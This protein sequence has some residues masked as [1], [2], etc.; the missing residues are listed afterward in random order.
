[1]IGL[2]ESRL[3]LGLFMAC[4]AIAGPVAAYYAVGTSEIAGEACGPAHPCTVKGAE[5][6]DEATAKARLATGTGPRIGSLADSR[7]ETEASVVGQLANGVN[8]YAFKFIFE[9][10][11]RVGV[12]AQELLERPDTKAAV[13]TMA[14]GLL[15]VDYAALGMREATFAQWQKSGVAALRADFKPLA[16]RSA[17]NEGPVTLVNGRAAN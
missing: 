14:N 1:M 13:L 5:V 17:K 11:F 16:T 4:L 6:D 10:K 15:G 7:M 3:R 2:T 8:V 12:V 9:D